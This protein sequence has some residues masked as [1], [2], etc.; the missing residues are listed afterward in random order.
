MTMG[1]RLL[2]LSAAAVLVGTVSTATPALA[3]TAPSVV[4]QHGGGGGQRRP[5]FWTMSSSTRLT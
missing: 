2:G 5:L 4:V 3:A 1:L